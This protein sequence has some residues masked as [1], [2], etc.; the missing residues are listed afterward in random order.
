MRLKLKLKIAKRK[1]LFMRNQNKHPSDEFETT[2]AAVTKHTIA[3]GISTVCIASSSGRIAQF[4][5][6]ADCAAAERA[7]VADTDTTALQIVE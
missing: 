4:R 7:G 3:G 6:T 2:C 5:S 1:W